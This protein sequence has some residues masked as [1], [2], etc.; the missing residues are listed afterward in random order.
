MHLTLK[1]RKPFSS[2]ITC[3]NFNCKA[4][5]EFVKQQMF[6]SNIPTSFL[7]PL[8]CPL[9]FQNVLGCPDFL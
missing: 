7:P 4:L 5:S 6:I 8:V 1:T 9:L 2:A 3:Q